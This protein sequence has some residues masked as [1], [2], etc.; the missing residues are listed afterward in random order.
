MAFAAPEQ[1]A[2]RH[3]AWPL[4][5]TV[6]C[7]VLLVAAIETLF[8]FTGASGV[9]HGVLIDPDCY[10]HL[11]RAYRLMTGGWRD[12][13]FDPRINAPF[14]YAI[15]WTV[16]FDALLAAGA[17]PLT[18]LGVEAHNALYL[19]GSLISPLLLMLALAIFAW[20]VRPWVQGPSFLWL[21][22]LLFTQPQL[23]GAFLIG[24][25]DHHSLILG[26]ML[27]QL[28]W[29]YAAADGRAGEGRPALAA[30]FLA[31]I[32]AGVELCTTVEGLLTLL[33][34]SLV[35]AIAWV[36]CRRPML[37]L[38]AAYWAGSLAMTLA[39]LMLTRWPV[40]FQPAYDRVSIVHVTVLGIGVIAIM[41]AMLLVRIMPRAAA[42]VVAG[43]FAVSIVGLLYPDFFAGPW[44]HLD[45]AVKAWHRQIGELQPLL[46]G[47]LFHIGQFLAAFAAC[48]IALPLTLHRLR[49]GDAGERLVMLTALC[50]FCLFGGLSLAQM[51]WSGEM[52][53][54]MLVPW[55]LTTQR[56]MKSSIALKLPRGRI[57]LRSAFLMA[58]LFLQITPSAF[59]TTIPGRMPLASAACDWDGAARALGRL[60]RQHGTVMTELWYGPDILWRSGFDVVGAPY[61]IAPAIAD[62]AL[63]EHG[64]A[65]GARR[66]LGR[67]HADFVLT[68]GARADAGA[69]DLVPLA[70]AVPGFH[71]YRV[72]H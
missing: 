4:A 24:R 54:V 35:L 69:L 46:P 41:V 38:L 19:W 5:R 14:G 23:S 63:F 66:V 36:W 15:H 6:L 62:S 33:L 17:A 26:L 45:P 49:H 34:V 1:P 9:R 53:A 72:G 32:G 50:G 51:R 57:P 59:A 47:D 25:A 3:T 12:Q 8:L 68:C 37:R 64:A 31:G 44:P 60:P 21:T 70:F 39:W 13:G 71:F 2:Q 30:A 58:A 55:T 40:F 7:A 43:A 61:E 56:I 27:A 67:R 10:M 29:L 20:G 65:P 42:L 48:L 11:Q 52:Q 28:A 18:W 22:L 16:L